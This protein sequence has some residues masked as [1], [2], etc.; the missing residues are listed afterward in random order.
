MP[1]KIKYPKRTEPHHRH[2]STLGIIAERQQDAILPEFY[3]EGSSVSQRD[4]NSLDELDESSI[5][6]ISGDWPRAPRR[7]KSHALFLVFQE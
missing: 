3:F 2:C 6:D 4:D 7:N 1:E 5:S